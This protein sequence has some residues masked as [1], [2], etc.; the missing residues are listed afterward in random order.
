MGHYLQ[1]ALDIA[2]SLFGLGFVI[3]MAVRSVKNSENPAGL[4]LKW[5]IT[6]LFVLACLYFALMLGPYGPFLI[7]L[8]AV[9]LSIMW[10]PHLSDWLVS[11][12]TNL[13]DGGTERPDNKPYYSIAITKRK[14]GKPVEAIVELRQ[15]LAKFPTDFEGVMLLAGI[16][17]EDMADLPGAEITLNKF[18]DSP[19]AAPRQVAAALTQLADWHMKLVQDTDSARAALQKIA[20]R[21]PDSE[22]ALRAQQRIAH[23]G[24]TAK[25]ILAAHDRQTIAVPEGVQNLGL[26]DSTSFIVPEEIEPGKLAAAYVKHLDEHPQD[27]EVREKLALIYAKDFKR[28]D[29][30]TLELAQLINEPKQPAKNVAHWLNLL[31]NLQI[32][33]GA[34]CLTVRETLEKIVERF[35][36]MPVA[37]IAQRRLARLESELRGQKETPSVKLGVYEQ[38]IGLKHGSP[39]QL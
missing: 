39:R 13:L 33:L 23:L 5:I 38:D 10:T 6:P 34:D 35:P 26:L 19:A 31:A 17:A 9:V 29:L 2:L 20:E 36:T 3:W 7:L 32:E 4:A 8:M 11:P 18:C 27:S 28:L 37:E 15:Q 16:Q 25:I 30:A 22:L 14:L 12:F 24:G 1:I 21:F